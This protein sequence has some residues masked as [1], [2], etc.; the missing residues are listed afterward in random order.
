MASKIKTPYREPL[1][2]DNCMFLLI[3]HQVGLL[4]FCTSMDPMVCKHNI[5]GLAE[6][7][8]AFNIP[9][10]L[11]TSWP[12][13]PNG[14]T[15]PELLDMFPGQEVIDRP[16]VNL[17]DHEQSVEAVKATGRKKLVIAGIALEVCVA[18]PAISA[19]REGYDVYAVV[20]AS[21]DFNPL[22]SQ[23]TTTKLATAGVSVTTWVN[24]LAELAKNTKQN[25]KYIAQFLRKH[26]GQYNVAVDNFLAT[27]KTAETI[28]G[29]V[30]F[31]MPTEP[32]YA[33]S[34][35]EEHLVEVQ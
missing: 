21:P 25:G 18:L 32:V 33:D 35:E 29:H 11:T 2:P 22:I 23:V 28:A 16:F 19:L 26:V 7:A 27:A 1:T 5:L 34:K 20:D 24:V 4:S 13:G 3:D 15:L 9:T 30:G 6:T 14:P 12:H 10:L 17:W 31:D 8:K